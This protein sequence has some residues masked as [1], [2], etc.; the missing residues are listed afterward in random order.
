MG[1]SL[2]NCAPDTVPLLAPLCGMAPHCSAGA[3][4]ILLL[5]LVPAALADGGE[6]RPRR[7]RHSEPFDR[8]EDG[9][10]EE[11]LLDDDYPHD[12]N[13][14]PSGQ[15]GEGEE[16]GSLLHCEEPFGRALVG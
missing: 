6:L 9:H 4:A 5:L 15:G 8:Y 3:A 13:D 7:G 14:S 2:G 12:Y 16:K 11:P 1:A 10:L